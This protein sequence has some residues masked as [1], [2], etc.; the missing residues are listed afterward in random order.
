[1]NYLKQLLII[2]L[3]NH[4]LYAVVGFGPG[5]IG[6]NN[7]VPKEFWTVKQLSDGKFMVVGDSGALASDGA[8]I[9]RFTEK[10][11]LD[12]TF[13]SA[14]Q[15][16]GYQLLIIVNDADEKFLDVI[17]T[18]D[19]K[20]LV[21]GETNQDALLVRYL[22]NGAI[23]EDFGANGRVTFDHFNTSDDK[24]WQVHEYSDGKILVCGSSQEA[25]G[26]ALLLK[27]NQDGN[28]TDNQFGTNGKVTFGND[29]VTFRGMV[30]LDNGKIVVV[31][32]QRG[33][34]TNVIIAQFNANGSPDDAFGTA[35]LTVL[36]RNNGTAE[37]N[38]IRKTSDGKFIV[39]GR[40]GL[41]DGTGFI[42][43]FTAQGL[44][45]TTFGT[46]SGHTLLTQSYLFWDCIIDQQERILAVG[47]NGDMQPSGI[48]ARFLPNGQLDTTFGTGGYVM[49]DQV[50]VLRG[51]VLT[52]D[53]K[54]VVCGDGKDN[55]GHIISLL[56][57]GTFDTDSAWNLKTYKKHSESIG[58]RLVLL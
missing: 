24:F 48:I 46:L 31:G 57:D 45:D 1:M 26:N 39:V 4:S 13:N 40:N 43:R 32:H 37:G 14:S 15:N 50:V 55:K 6:Y 17:E 9:A 49:I 25:S 38:A 3:L 34:S 30:V 56:S 41:N 23:D 51:V 12:T 11:A 22:S 47:R 7:A 2:L 27:L 10:G 16:P 21:A 58:K 54:I 28:G 29:V 5:Q 36:N 18:T 52:Q 19:H 8:V 53:Q 20:L 33:V 35:G 42:A 44:L